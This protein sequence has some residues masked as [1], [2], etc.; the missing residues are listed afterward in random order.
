MEDGHDDGMA[1]KL[2]QDMSKSPHKEDENFTKPALTLE[3][4]QRPI[5]AQD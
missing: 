1:E 3:K 4:Q 2:S 5:L